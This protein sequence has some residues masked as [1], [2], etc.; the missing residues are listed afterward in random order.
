MS[1]FVGRRD[2]LAT[3]E[4]L[5]ASER[6]EM[7]VLYGRRRVGK[8]SLLEQFCID[9]KPL[10]FTAQVQS[11]ID[12]LRDFSRVVYERYGLPSSMSAFS[13]WGDALQFV[14]ERQ[15]VDGGPLVFVFD[16]FPYAANADPALPSALQ[17][18]ID[19]AFGNT[20]CLLVLCGSN[21][22]FMENEV[23]AEK[24]PLY[25][26]R[27]AQLKLEPFDYRDAALM[28]PNCPPE[29][30]V[31]Y[32]ASLG[33]TP[34]YLAGVDAGKS[35][36]E[37]MAALF[38]ER[39]GIMFDE[40][41]MLMRQELREPAAYGSV[42]RAIAG[43]ANRSN[44][45]AD[46]VGISPTSITAYLKTLIGLGLVERRVPFGEG[47]RSKRSIYRIEDPAFSFWYRFVAPYVAAIEGGLGE[48][49][50]GRL[51]KSDMRSE[52]EG[53]LFE[54]VCN[55]WVLRQARCGALPLEPTFVGSWWGTDPL[56][57]AQTDIDL[58]AADDI[59]G[60]LL[61][62]ECK[63]RNEVDETDVVRTLID[64]QR[65]IP[66]YRQ[67]WS[68]LFTKKRVSDATARKF[69]DRPDVAFVC[70]ED[71]YA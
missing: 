34:Y 5:Y 46:R 67:R 44:E 32:Y 24:S 52:Y 38:F 6:F 9:K 12:N 57:H 2:E 20:R 17:V 39:S 60:K 43:G 10:W 19:R 35:Y 69:A 55:Q 15:S 64:R 58:V 48:R 68:Y 27:T 40:P 37:N 3:L 49:L 56:A 14:A 13:A 31:S 63:W 65:L 41:A 66:G 36:I 45:I 21:Q 50:A 23:L 4:R 16:E 28:L 70:A 59:D 22:G 26:R 54:R 33:G 7:L 25:G 29:E 61:L 30:L 42:L 8:T 51:L 11:N 62:G 18:A 71:L 47:E 1:G 53:H